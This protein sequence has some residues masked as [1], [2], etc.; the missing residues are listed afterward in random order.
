[1]TTAEKL[2]EV[3]GKL[4]PSALAELL[5]FAEF[6]RQR[7]S[8]PSETGETVTL[9]ELAGGLE[10]SKVLAGSPMEIQEKLRHEWD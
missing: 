4:P 1:M 3:S 9:L 7:S 8:S 5:D 10:D 6:L 2:Y